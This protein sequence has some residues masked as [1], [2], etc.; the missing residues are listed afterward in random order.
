LTK[1]S[2]I[3]NKVTRNKSN[4]KCTILYAE[5][6][7][8]SLEVSKGGLNS[9]S[10]ILFMDGKI[11]I[12]KMSLLPTL[13]CRFHVVLTKTLTGIN[14]KLDTLVQKFM[15]QWLR[16]ASKLQKKFLKK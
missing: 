16:I 1:V 13:N 12:T 7:K 8:L 3:K 11:Q 9:W 10:D 15:K 2:T 6:H 4:Q 14:N 5:K